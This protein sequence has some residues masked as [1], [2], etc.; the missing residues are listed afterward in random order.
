LRDKLKLAVVEMNGA[1]RVHNNQF[2]TIGVLFNRSVTDA[3]L[4]PKPDTLA[5]CMLWLRD[6]GTGGDA[7]A[8]SVG[9][10]AAACAA[11]MASNIAPFNPLDDVSVLGIDAPK[12]LTDWI[13][14]GAS[15]ESEV[16][17]GQGN[18]PL[19][20]KPNGEVAFVRTV[21]S[22]IS[23]DG[24]G[25]PEVTAYYDVQDFN[26]LYFFRK[27]IFTRFSQPDFKQRKLSDETAREVKAETIRLMQAFEDQGMFQKV[28]ELG[29]LVQVERNISDRH[30]LDVKI[31]V[32]V[33]PGLHV[34]ATNIEAGTLF[35]IITI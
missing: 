31:P 25:A 11:K 7:P 18:T 34:L 6:S 8:Y 33:V 9:E 12:K 20:V 19:K 28:Q 4:L 35:D 2:G 23:A 5:L 30:R 32:N 10:M 17:L 24:T 16:C 27:T 15:L 29:K 1:Q 22:R 14:V 13:S 21:T 26:C 3:S